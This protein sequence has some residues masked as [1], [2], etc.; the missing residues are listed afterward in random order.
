MIKVPTDGRPTDEANSADLIGCDGNAFSIMGTTKQL[1]QHYGASKA[2]IASY[3]NE[4]MS[5][6]YDHLIAAS[7]AYLDSHEE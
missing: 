2:Y 3:M 1:L 6:D 7:C 5:G 4:A